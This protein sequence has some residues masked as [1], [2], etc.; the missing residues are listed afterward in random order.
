MVIHDRNP[1]IW[2]V[3]QEDCHEFEVSAGYTVGSTL[4]LAK[5]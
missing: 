4:A 3:G 2:K 5:K 1:S